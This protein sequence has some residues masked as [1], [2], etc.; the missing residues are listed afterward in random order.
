MYLPDG[1]P[2]GYSLLLEEAVLTAKPK[3]RSKGPK[4]PSTGWQLPPVR[5]SRAEPSE[6]EGEQLARALRAGRS[7]RRR[8]LHDSL[9][10]DLAGEL[11]ISHV[12]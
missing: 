4:E 8:Y 5:Q 6:E 11:F 3:R 10:R 2:V 12:S 9:L 1:R 7:R